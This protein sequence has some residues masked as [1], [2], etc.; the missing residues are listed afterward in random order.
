MVPSGELR[1][2]SGRAT[3]R[4][5]GREGEIGK[6]NGPA[7]GATCCVQLSKAGRIED[8]GTKGR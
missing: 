3:A 7:P 6:G 5:R 8:Q 4:A 1:P 2:Y